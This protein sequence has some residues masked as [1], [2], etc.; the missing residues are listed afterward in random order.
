MTKAQQNWDAKGY[1]GQ[2][3]FLKQNPTFKPEDYGLKMATNGTPNTTQ[4]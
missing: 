3:S 4:Q 1:Q 2:Q